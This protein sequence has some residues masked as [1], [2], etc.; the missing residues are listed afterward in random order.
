MNKRL[1]VFYLILLMAVPAIAAPPGKAP[2]VGKATA[3]DTDT[4]IDVNK[5]LMIVANDGA[6]ATDLGGTLGKTDGLY[7]PFTSVEDIEDGSNTSSVVYASGL[8]IGAV[9]AATSDTLICLAEYSEEYGPGPMSGGTFQP[10]AF[11]N[12]AYEV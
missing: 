2:I 5:I 1:L 10:D 7:Y 4:W 3:L 6:F 9:D 12:A 11:E 8:W